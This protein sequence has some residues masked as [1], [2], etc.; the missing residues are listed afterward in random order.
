MWGPT[1]AVVNGIF[2]AEI[3]RTTYEIIKTKN[4]KYNKNL[5]FL[6]SCFLKIPQ[7]LLH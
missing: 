7:I 6:L 4:G 3:F 5:P 1:L 2:F